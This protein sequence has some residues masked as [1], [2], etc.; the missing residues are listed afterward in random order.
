MEEYRIR[1][2][3]FLIL[4][5]SIVLLSSQG[6]S[7]SYLNKS[8]ADEPLTLDNDQDIKIQ[9]NT[10]TDNNQEISTVPSQDSEDNNQTVNNL[11]D[12]VSGVMV[13]RFLK[14]II[15]LQLRY[16]VKMNRIKILTKL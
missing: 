9:D 4:S 3:C 1:I 15:K 16:P 7:S 11:T 12:E 14:R 6:T 5:F 8:W 10:D 2:A 13:M